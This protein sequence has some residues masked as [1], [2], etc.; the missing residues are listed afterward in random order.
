MANKNL[1]SDVITREAL[2]VLHEKLNFL[3]KINT[4]YDSEFAQSGAKIGDTVRIRKPAQFNVRDGATMSTQDFK[5]EQTS[6]KLDIRKGVDVTFNSSELTLELDDFSKRV[7]DPA[8]SRLAA[9]LQTVIIER[10]RAAVG[11]VVLKAGATVAFKDFLIGQAK[12]DGQAAPR[13]NQ[14]SILVDPMTNVEIVDQLKGLY[15]DSSEIAKQYREGIIA[16]GGGASWYSNSNLPSLVIPA[17]IAGSQVTAV[18]AADADYGYRTT[19]SV[20]GLTDGHVI[21]KGTA[22]TVAGV[23]AVQPETKRALPYLKTFVV[24]ADVTVAGG[25]LAT[26]SVL[27]FCFAA[28]NPRNNVSALPAAG[29]AIVVL[30]TANTTYGTNLVFHKDAFTFATAD[31]V[32][33]GGVDM[34]SRATF[35][36]LS[37]RMIRQYQASDDTFPVRFDILGAFGSLRPEL[38]CAIL[39]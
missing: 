22:L 24:Q 36:G 27:P 6:L 26:L 3:T 29:N 4:A 12:L 18:G 10:A 37:L 39:A 11:S 33:P 15:Q 23:Y 20:N 1:T 9:E 16:V 30:G 35:D 17:D 32:L 21:A 8:M 2:R 14:R 38:A 25:G 34:A 31:L 19:I 13:D 5:E 28:G 7:L